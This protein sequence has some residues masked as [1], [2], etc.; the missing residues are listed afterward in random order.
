M[1]RPATSNWEDE[2]VEE[3][4]SS[5]HCPNSEK[6]RIELEQKMESMMWKMNMFF[7]SV[8]CVLVGSLFM[9]VVMK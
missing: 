4:E 3:E 5:V 1:V 8:V 9:Y 6:N 7:V 2:N